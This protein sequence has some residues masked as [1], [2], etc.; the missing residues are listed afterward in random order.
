MKKIWVLSVKTSLPNV[1]HDANDLVTEIFAFESFESAKDALYDKYMELAYSTNEMFDGNGVLLGL[2]CYIDEMIEEKIEDES[3]LT[4]ALCNKI[5]LSLHRVLYKKDFD[6]EIKDGRYDDGMICV[7]VCGNEVK[8]SGAGCGPINGYN[9]VLH[10]NIFNMAEKK[11]YFLYINDL[12]GQETS[13]E[14]Y[15]DLQEVE[16]NS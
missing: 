7:E 1:C 11:D 5:K 6:L 10:T 14:L 16:L 4:K 13:S 3:F 12:F 2:D 9:P 8:F 15:I